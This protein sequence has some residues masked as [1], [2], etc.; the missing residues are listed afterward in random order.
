MTTPAAA[1]PQPAGPELTTAAR[2]PSPS[3]KPAAKPARPATPPAGEASEG[4]LKAARNGRPA[5]R[6]TF[7]R[8]GEKSPLE[9]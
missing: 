3:A 7:V 5:I 8:P 1:A 4:T 6:I 2:A 9:K